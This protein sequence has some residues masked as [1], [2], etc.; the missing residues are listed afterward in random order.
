MIN[1]QYIYNMKLLIILVI[2]SFC[3]TYGLTIERYLNVTDSITSTNLENSS[4]KKKPKSQL[5][6]WE[7][8]SKDFL[9][10]NNALTNFNIR[11][12]DRAVIRAQ[13]WEIH[14]SDSLYEMNENSILNGFQNLINTFKEIGILINV[15]GYD[16]IYNDSLYYFASNQRPYDLL[17]SFSIDNAINF[18]YLPNIDYTGGTLSGYAEALGIGARDLMI[19]GND[20]QYIGEELVCYDLANTFIPIHELGHCLGLY[21]PHSNTY[22]YENVIRPNNEDIVP[23][24]E[25]NCNYTGDFLCDTEATLNIKNDVSYD[26]YNC[27]YELVETDSCGYIYQPQINNIMSYTHFECANVFTSEQIDRMFYYIENN[28][29]VNQTVIILGD[30]NDDSEINIIDIIIV[31]NTILISENIL[32]INLW[33]GDLNFDENLNILDIMLII[34]IIINQ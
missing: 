21:H 33:L 9:I 14:R 27:F 3:F 10:N 4:N 8:K 5:S 12:N 24:C 6:N 1:T 19:A 20:C 23:P 17:T 29:I 13:I 16:I 30:L 7:C 22:G 34:D 11:E 25:I 26:G 15:Y 18:F 28:N 2:L 31:I 32:D